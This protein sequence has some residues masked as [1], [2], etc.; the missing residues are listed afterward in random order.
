[1]HFTVSEDLFGSETSTNA[2]NAFTAGVKGRFREADLD[3]D[4]HQL[5]DATY[6]VLMQV[7]G[8]FELVEQ[9]ALQA[10]NA[11]LRDDY[12]RDCETGL[13]RWNRLIKKAGFDFQLKLPHQAF[14]RQVGQFSDLFVTP[15]GDIIGEDEW[16]AQESTWLP[17]KEDNEYVSSLM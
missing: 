1:F 12:I 5:A 6:P 9:P 17:S 11:R 14:H 16:R 13:K 4:D 2:A 7:N 10:R 15:D 3:E 8:G